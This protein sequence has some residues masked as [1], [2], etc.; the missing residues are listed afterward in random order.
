MAGVVS[1][2][3]V[4]VLAMPSSGGRL[5]RNCLTMAVLAVPGPPTSRVGCM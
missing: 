5:S 3:K 1:D 4:R 2:E